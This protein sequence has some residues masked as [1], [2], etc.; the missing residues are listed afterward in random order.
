MA[1]WVLI[2]PSLFVWVRSK[3]RIWYELVCGGS[4]VNE[5]VT[6]A[7]DYVWEKSC[8]KKRGVCRDGK[9]RWMGR[10]LGFY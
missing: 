3:F 8:A 5:A 6:D 2:G 1:W 9:G 4:A 10:V 7:R